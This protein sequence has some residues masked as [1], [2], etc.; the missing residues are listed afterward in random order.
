MTNQELY[1]R[2]QIQKYYCPKNNDYFLSGN[3]NSQDFN[4]IKTNHCL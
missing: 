3:Y 4:A 2:L 1:N